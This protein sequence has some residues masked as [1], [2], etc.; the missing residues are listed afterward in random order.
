MQVGVCFLAF[1]FP[2]RLQVLNL[3]G[4]PRLQQLDTLAHVFVGGHQLI[5]SLLRLGFGLPE[6]LLGRRT[7]R[8]CGVLCLYQVLEHVP[9]RT[10]MG[11]NDLESLVCA[12]AYL[13]E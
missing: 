13:H 1:G 11:F 12:R 4:M 10:C 2:A 6:R 3:F 7:P 5:F 8:F 9:E